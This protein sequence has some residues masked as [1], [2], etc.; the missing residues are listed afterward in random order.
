MD[1]DVVSCACRPRLVVVHPDAHV[2]ALV[3]HATPP[4]LLP[5]GLARGSHLL[6]WLASGSGTTRL[7]VALD[8]ARTPAGPLRERLPRT[9]STH[10]LS[11]SD[12]RLDE[13]DPAV[14]STLPRRRLTRTSLAR[15]LRGLGL[16]GSTCVC[17]PATV[18]R[19]TAVTA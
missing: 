2:R 14:D 6:T 18:T 19:P 1:L 11:I 9:I 13:P 12:L 16:D 4:L 5:L 10:L 7:V 3:R 17:P 15:H 8:P